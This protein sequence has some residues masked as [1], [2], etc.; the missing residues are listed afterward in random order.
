MHNAEH[1]TKLVSLPPKIHLRALNHN[2]TL[3][4]RH[5]QK[6]IN[7]KQWRNLKHNNHQIKKRRWTT[8]NAMASENTF[9][10]ASPETP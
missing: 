7:Q 9:Q 1:F 8:T 6:E 4:S 10:T 2:N 5:C 3:H